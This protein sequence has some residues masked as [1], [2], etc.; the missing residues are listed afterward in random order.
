MFRIPLDLDLGFFVG[1]DLQQIALGRHH[2]QFM[3][4]S[5]ARIAVQ[6]KVGVIRN[7][8]MV[9]EWNEEDGWSSLGFQGLLNRDVTGVR[10]VNDRLI[11]LQ[12][13]D[14]IALELHDSSEINLNRC[15]YTHQRLEQTSS[16]FEQARQ[17]I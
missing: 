17:S 1:D 4:G 2:V 9:A 6:G 5:G 13:S 12:F 11:E 7:G 3:F 16:L 8:A 10:V 14:S 15:R